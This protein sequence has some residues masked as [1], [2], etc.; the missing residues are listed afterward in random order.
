MEN[1]KVEIAK[2]KYLGHNS[3]SFDVKIIQE[4]GV[5]TCFTVYGSRQNAKKQAE[6]FIKGLK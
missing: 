6:K 1:T 5:T 2:G 3:K 4:N